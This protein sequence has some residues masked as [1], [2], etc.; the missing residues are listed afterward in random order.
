M[1]SGCGAVFRPYTIQRS[2]ICSCSC[3]CSCSCRWLDLLGF[4]IIA[5]FCYIIRSKRSICSICFI[6]L[7][8]ACLHL[9]ATASRHGPLLLNLFVPVCISIDHRLYKV[10][11]QAQT[12]FEA[13][14]YTGFS[15]IQY[16]PEQLG[17]LCIS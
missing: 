15:I 17:L 7:G 5:F 8:F 1:S 2:C 6:S 16:C 10:P 11:Y 3:S 4:A 14:V 13:W 9:S 12:I